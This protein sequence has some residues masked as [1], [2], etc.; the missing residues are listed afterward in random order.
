MVQFS[1]WVKTQVHR[2][3]GVGRLATEA[4]NNP[5]WPKNTDFEGCLTYLKKAWQGDPLQTPTLVEFLIMAWADYKIVVRCT[6]SERA[7]EKSA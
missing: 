3:D 5:N 7:I 6:P 4:F 2:W 1:D